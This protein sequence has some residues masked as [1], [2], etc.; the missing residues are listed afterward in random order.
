MSRVLN[1][2]SK[3][4]D[5][6]LNGKIVL[7]RVDHNVVKDGII[8]D[9][10]RID[11]TFATLF[12]ILA[13]GGKLILMS[14]VGRPKDKK[15]GDIKASDKTAVQPI[16]EY[17]KKKLHLEFKIPEFNRTEK[18][19]LEWNDSSIKELIS[20]LREGKINGIYLPNTRWFKGEE[21]KGDLAAEFAQQL[22]KIADVYVNDAFGSWQPHVST[23]GITEHLPSYA[24]ILMQKEIRNL[25]NIFSPER[26]F[27][28][29]V[30]GSK[31]DTKIGPLRALLEKADY[32]MLGGIIYNA[33]LAAKYDLEIEG[34]SQDD[35]EAAKEFLKFS[36]QYKDKIIE[37]SVVIESD[38]L[39]G[40]FEGKYR[41]VDI[42]KLSSGDKLKYILDAAPESF[43]EEK[44]K[45][46]I[47]KAKSVFINAV[48]G[49]TP[50]FT[51]GTV[52]LL[53]AVA[54]NNEAFKMLAGGD[55]LQEFRI[56]CP[57]KYLAALDDSQYYFFSGGGTILT[58]IEQNSA[59]GLKPVKVLLV[60]Q[61]DDKR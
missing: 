56:L 46:I 33:Y 37:P 35:I 24:G 61:N 57:G 21:D 45:V 30:A 28:A 55:T 13:K 41:K 2:I 32:L 23:V 15:T 34:L 5:A 52:A 44:V 48:M 10:F 47:S 54:D 25:D 11:I 26:P 59:E 31:F 38:S 42:R 40:K 17:L 9:P 19:G 6:D 8:K 49:L 27:L 39:E 18:D 3:I 20:S 58:A 50:H 12:N 22:A 4:Q 51:E 29:V 60:A 53:N 14:H 16:V 1:N 43:A 36:R 7:I